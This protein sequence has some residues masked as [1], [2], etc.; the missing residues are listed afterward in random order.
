MFSG[1]K[2]AF[3]IALALLTTPLS[4]QVQLKR[5]ATAKAVNNFP[6]A[7]NGALWIDTPNGSVTVTGTDRRDVY[8]ETTTLIRAADDEALRVAKSQARLFF[9]GDPTKRVF[10]AVFPE[11]ESRWAISV[12][13]A[14]QVP[15]T[16]FVNILAGSEA[17]VS[18]SSL[19]GPLF[20]RTIGGVIELNDALGGLDVDSANANIFVNY[21]GPPRVPGRIFS[22]NGTIE[23]H[24][25]QGAGMGWLADTLNGD[26]L[27]AI[28]TAGGFAPRISG[29]V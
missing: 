5:S 21:S 17:K 20:I 8:V 24:V 7:M 3:V 25:P 28:N 15:R 26:I 10:K 19:F 14:V 16:L 4:A 2:A 29:H 13:Y 23:L 11:A 1:S 12:S 27:T 22:L 18:V 6:A 9:G